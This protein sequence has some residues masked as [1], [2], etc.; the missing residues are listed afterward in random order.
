MLNT[1]HKENEN[2]SRAS[3]QVERAQ[4]LVIQIKEE[5][6]K[7]VVGQKTVIHNLLLCLIAGGHVLLDGV[8]GLAKTLIIRSISQIFGASFKRIQFTPDL[9]PADLIGTMVY[10]QQT[11]EFL[12]R[13]GPIF[14]NVV[15]ADEI[16]RAPAKVQS[17]MLEAMEERQVTIGDFS[18]PLPDPFFVMA[19]Q[20]PI[21]QEGTYP[22]PEAELDRFMM[23][24]LVHYPTE[25]EELAI[26]YRMS[27]DEVAEL[28][29]IVDKKE[30]LSLQHL[31][32]QITLDERIA[33][34]IVSLIIMTRPSPENMTTF[35]RFV[36]FGASPRATIALARGARAQAMMKGRTYVLPEDVK[37]IA[38]HVLRHRIVL[39]YEAEAEQ[40]SADEILDKIITS[41][42][43]P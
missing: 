21:E 13:K 37:E 23:K 43:V 33:Q 1:E 17:A 11:G 30:I 10:R 16:N 27:G 25:S 14:T 29:K 24:L 19:T 5:I 18:Y 6:A 4:R 35:A 38:K 2:S 22:L 9:L 32:A 26:L 15:L 39:S 28:Q 34:Y 36:E 3:A 42:A 12:P 7:S 40:L 8:P 20:N 31:L 41:V